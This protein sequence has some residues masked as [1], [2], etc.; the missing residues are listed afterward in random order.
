V[1]QGRLSCIDTIELVNDVPTVVA[2]SARDLEQFEIE[3]S[4]FDGRCL[5]WVYRVPSTGYVITMT[6]TSEEPNLLGIRWSNSAGDSGTQ[7]L[8]RVDP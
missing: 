2:G 3:S 4:R 8:F 1:L 7:S 5:T 6:S